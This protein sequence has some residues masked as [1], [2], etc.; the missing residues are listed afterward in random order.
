MTIRTRLSLW[1]TVA[2][3]LP[4]IILVLF[5]VS[6]AGRRFRSRA[7]EELRQAQESGERELGQFG[8]EITGTLERAVDSPIVEQFLL[9]VNGAGEQVPRGHFGA[10]QR[11]GLHRFVCGATPDAF[12]QQPD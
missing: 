9:E 8:D 1:F 5:S 7:I 11:P 3:L 10:V 2:A 12:G 4:A 6:E